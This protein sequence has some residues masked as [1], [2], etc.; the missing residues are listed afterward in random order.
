MAIFLLESF[1]NQSTISVLC[2]ID[3]SV[4]EL[5]AYDLVHCN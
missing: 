1:G 2:L 5:P 3:V 4:F